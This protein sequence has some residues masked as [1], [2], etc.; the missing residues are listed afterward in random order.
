MTLPARAA[1]LFGFFTMAAS[2]VETENEHLTV[3]AST[4][5]TEHLTVAASEVAPCVVVQDELLTGFSI[6]LWRAIEDRLGVTSDIVM[7]TFAEKMAAIR[8]GQADVAIGCISTTS[9]R[10]EL[11]DFTHPVA[12]SGFQAMSLVENTLLP[13][14]SEESIKMLLLL[15][16]FVVVFAHLMWWSEH[17]VATISD[18]YFPGVLES[19]WFSVVTMSTVGYGDI[20]PR[21]WVGRIS[22]VLLILTGV[23]SFGIIFGQF[24]ADAIGEEARHQ[25]SDVKDLREL[26]VATKRGTA[27]DDWLTTSGVDPVRFE[28]NVDAVAALQDEDVDLVVLDQI[29]VEN[30]V[31]K[32]ADLLA[33]GPMFKKHFLG[34]ALPQGSKWRE[35]INTALLEMQHNGLYESIRTRWLD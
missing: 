6:D 35:P 2:A 16:V 11:L 4:A 19:I 34:I 18:R 9:E 5:E 13:R 1:L 7:S 26:R 24:A 29:V 28:E 14:F 27:A 33:V 23:T 25:V 20:A 32:N 31:Q 17:G 8:G 12:E 10:E 15:F 21:R 30:F 22:A 3:A